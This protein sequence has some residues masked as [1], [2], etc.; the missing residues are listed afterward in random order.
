MK[1][2]YIS[3]LIFKKGSSASIR[4]CGL[5]KG[6]Q[7]LD[8]SVDL[9]TIKYVDEMEDEYL[10][11]KIQKNTKIYK[12]E[13][14][15]LSSYL[16][17]KKLVITNNKFLLFIKNLIKDIIF[18][19]DVDKEWLFAYKNHNIDINNY[20]LV[21]SSSDT[22][23]SHFIADKMLKINKNIKW[24]QIWGDPWADDIGISIL[25]KIRIF[26]SERKIINKAD[27]VLYVSPLTLEKMKR[28][29]LIPSLKL[30][31]IPR[32]YLE[33]IRS[34][35]LKKENELVFTYTGILNKNRNII[36]FLEKL[37]KYLRENS[38]SKIKLKIY[39]M[40]D[41]NTKNKLLNYTFVK[42]YGIVDFKEIISIYKKSDIL[43]FIDN[44]KNTTQIPGKIYDYLG[45]DKKIVALFNNK[46]DIYN[47][48]KE[49]L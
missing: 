45:T 32:G 37:N 15:I 8:N 9:L 43:I 13:L 20:D 3:S 49:K 1:I 34:S 27:K 7:E 41:N 19:P 5:I 39:G 18:F 25:K 33:E 44:G 6:L 24:I 16:K 17:N 26:I 22:K 31:F 23:T 48:F 40:I 38:Y 2:L 47:Y 42:Y 10:I 46:N 12:S 14:N 30:G 4:N 29:M 35:D 28:K 21:I 11:Q 36:P